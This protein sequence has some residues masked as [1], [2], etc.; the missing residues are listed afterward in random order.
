MGVVGGRWMGVVGGG[1]MGVV[2]GGW[3]VVV[4]GCVNE[5]VYLLCLLVHSLRCH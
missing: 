5:A 2:G 1:W 4:G 3:M